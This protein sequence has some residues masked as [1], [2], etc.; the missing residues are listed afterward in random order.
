MWISECILFCLSRWSLITAPT[1]LHIHNLYIAITFTLFFRFLCL[2]CC[3][4]AN[5]GRGGYKLRLFNSQLFLSPSHMTT[6]YEIIWDTNLGI[7]SRTILNGMGLW[8]NTQNEDKPELSQSNLGY[9]FS[10]S[11]IL[12][13]FALHEIYH[14]C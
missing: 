11:F 7:L 13:N 2:I 3:Y 5:P 4:Q 8:N 10:C 6:S 9:N 14:L 12:Y 1:S